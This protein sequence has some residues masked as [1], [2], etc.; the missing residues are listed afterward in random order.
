MWTFAEG[1]DQSLAGNNEI[2]LDNLKLTNVTKGD[3]LVNYNFEYKNNGYLSNDASAF[4]TDWD[5]PNFMHLD[6]MYDGSWYESSLYNINQLTLWEPE[7]D[8]FAK[9]V[10][11]P[12]GLKLGDNS[13]K[14]TIIWTLYF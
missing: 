5:T 4:S 2:R 12:G 14:L 10:F 6:R 7:F 11:F 9:K 3:I 8:L 1:L 13:D